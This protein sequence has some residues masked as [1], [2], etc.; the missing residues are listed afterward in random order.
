METVLIAVGLLPATTGSG[1]ALRRSND[2]GAL[3]KTPRRQRRGGGP[4]TTG[5]GL[6]RKGMRDGDRSRAPGSTTGHEDCGG[7]T[8]VGGEFRRA[9][10]PL[11]ANPEPA[12]TGIHISRREPLT[13]ARAS[14]MLALTRSSLAPFTYKLMRTIRSTRASRGLDKAPRNGRGMVA[15]SAG[16]YILKPVDVVQAIYQVIPG[17]AIPG[18]LIRREP[19]TVRVGQPRHEG[20]RRGMASVLAELHGTQAALM[21]CGRTAGG[22]QHNSRVRRTLGAMCGSQVVG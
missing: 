16:L 1:A 20:R 2:G 11:S 8:A 4:P 3:L 13:G 21:L 22:P 7:V 15:Y 12:A 10:V 18:D 9:S 5:S 6:L 14:A 19:V 17:R